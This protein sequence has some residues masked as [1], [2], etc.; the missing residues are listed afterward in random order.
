MTFF[1][2]IDRMKN[3]LTD[4]NNNDEFLATNSI[5]NNN[6]RNSKKLHIIKIKKIIIKI[7]NVE[8]L[9]VFNSKAESQFDK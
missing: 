9:I 5:D 7:N 3:S 4:D 8:T 6:K 1:N 2:Q